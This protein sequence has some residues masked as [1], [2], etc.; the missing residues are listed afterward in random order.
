MQE[1]YRLRTNQHWARQTCLDCGHGERIKVVIIS[2]YLFEELHFI[3]R[4]RSREKATKGEQAIT[5]LK[6]ASVD[7]QRLPSRILEC[8][9]AEQGRRRRGLQLVYCINVGSHEWRDRDDV[10]NIVVLVNT[11]RQISRHYW[12]RS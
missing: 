10:Y 2:I 4:V 5:K 3:T 1:C 8:A 9:D 6:V 11:I 12:T 7:Q